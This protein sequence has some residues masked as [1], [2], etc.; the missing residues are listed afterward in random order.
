MIL[1]AIFRGIKAVVDA[2][3]KA[4]AWLFIAL[5]LW[6]PLLYTL[7][8]VVV[9]AFTSYTMAELSTIYFFGL[10]VAVAGAML[11]SMMRGTGKTK[12]RKHKSQAGYNISEVQRKNEEL[13]ERETPP[14]IQN[15]YTY[16]EPP[17]ELPVAPKYLTWEQQVQ[18]Y[19][20]E[21][22]TQYM[23]PQ[24][25]EPVQSGRWDEPMGRNYNEPQ[26]QSSWGEPRI[27]GWNEPE[28]PQTD[29]WRT[30]KPVER[31][32]R[33]KTDRWGAPISDSDVSDVKSD[34]NSDAW[35]S[36]LYDTSWSPR[37]RDR[38]ANSWEE[39]KNNWDEPDWLKPKNDR[40][41]AT[42]NYSPKTTEWPTNWD[43]PQ[44]DWE[45]RGG[46]RRRDTRAS[47]SRV[48]DNNP[49]DNW[50]PYSDYPRQSGQNYRSSE[51]Q[52]YNKYNDYNDD[53]SRPMD[54]GRN[55]DRPMRDY[56]EPTGG[57]DRPMRDYGEPT[58]GYNRPM[59][60]YGEPTD[61]NNR[62]MRDYGEPTGGYDRPMVDYNEPISDETHRIFRLRED[63]NV[64]VYEY[65]DRLDYYRRS[66]SGNNEF[67]R[68]KY[69]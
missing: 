4:I 9:V 26:L 17:E 6:I 43:K 24:Q 51:P 63:P 27:T 28:K 65:S 46:D 2:V 47:D 18:Q 29:S 7:I 16:Y 37:S 34:T 40:R 68:R 45:P 23:V 21:Q 12:E 49:I 60:D 3:A 11:F 25:S 62:P 33:P 42:D 53:Y 55:Y 32:E 35:N 41:N 48:N 69:K 8:F 20:E 22:K 39:Q 14:T 61:G 31:E 59:R 57:Y 38:R 66:P 13:I 5:G 44:N 1:N 19:R 30:I 58:G 10:V 67:I 64:L 36:G 56:G 52:S 50:T 15:E 54:N